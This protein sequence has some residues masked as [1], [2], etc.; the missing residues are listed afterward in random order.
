MGRTQ[1]MNMQHVRHQHIAGIFQPTGHFARGVDAADILADIVAL[2]GVDAVQHGH[3]QVAVLHVARQFDGV[4]N[5]LV[6]GAAADVAAEPFLDLFAVGKGVDA[7]RRGRRHH[8]AGNA[9]AALAGAGLV[10]GLL[11]HAQFAGLGQRLDSVDPGAL[12]LRHRQQARLHQHAI[13]EHR[14]G[15]AFA[16]AAA[17]LVAGQ[18]EV[19]ANEIEQTLRRLRCTRNLAPVDD[20]AERKIRHRRPQVRSTARQDRH[21]RVWRP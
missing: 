6:A 15:A 14:T 1:H 11:Q 2:L 7:Q 17:F 12:H 4:E 16:G 18:V 9:V 8:H 19:V 20:R 10:E 13:D 21:R 3:R 5:L